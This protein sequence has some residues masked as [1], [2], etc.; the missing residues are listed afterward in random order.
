VGVCE[1]APSH[2]TKKSQAKK[3][4]WMVGLPDLTWGTSPEMMVTTKGQHPINSFNVFSVLVF[5][6]SV[7]FCVFAQV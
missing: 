6:L 2:E 5:V 4:A 1:V 7:L 3:I